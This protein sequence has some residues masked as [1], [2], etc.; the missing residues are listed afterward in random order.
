MTLLD[1]LTVR[2]RIYALA[3]LGVGFALLLVAVFFIG[4][5]RMDQGDVRAAGYEAAGERA[6]ALRIAGLEI[7]RAEKDM[8]LRRDARYVDLNAQARR[9]ATDTVD[10]MLLLTEIQPVRAELETVRD[11]L[12]RYGEAFDAAWGNMVR[13]G[14]DEKSGAQGRLR[15]AVHGVEE[16]VKGVDDAP[17]MVSLLTLRRHEKDFLLRGDP[18]YIERAEKESA[19]FL[20]RLSAVVTDDGARRNLQEKTKFY[21]EKLK[22][23]ALA[24]RESEGAVKRLSDVYAA[25]GPALE[26]VDNFTDAAVVEEKQKME[27]LDSRIRWMIAALSAGGL[28]LSGVLALLISRSIIAPLHQVAGIMSDL[29]AGRRGLP[30]PFTDAGNEIGDMTRALDGFQRGLTEGERLQ[31][32]AK[33]AA[34]RELARADQRDRMVASYDSAVGEM[35]GKVDGAVG[36]VD[37]AAKDM[38]AAAVQVTATSE[39]AACAAE[40]VSANVQTVAA[41]ANELSATTGEISRRVQQ[42]SAISQNAVS[43]IEQTTGEVENLRGM[44]GKIGEVVHLIEAI[45]NQTNLLALNATIEAARAGEAGKGFAVVASEVKNLANQTAKA[46]GDIQEQIAE[47]Q[48]VTRDVVVSI[49]QARTTIR[50]VDEVVTSIASAVEEQNAATQEIARNVQEVAGA[51]ATVA[52]SMN[53]IN[54]Q[55]RVARSLADGLDHAAIDLK[56]GAGDMNRRTEN[57]L[58]EIKAI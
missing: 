27:A 26:K 43:S 53:D 55:A 8:L 22:E 34:Q 11:G 6:M 17:L 9:K 16:A 30:I 58:K 37:Q 41:A 20:S 40:E 57:F 33:A 54:N 25:F 46:T 47:I 32:E 15:E 29:G 28:G 36:Q 44:A 35:L 13:A 38:H 19:V 49:A 23:M 56:K 1:K 4:L 39:S 10:A 5:E 7:R 24:T 51:N 12:K 42:T 21:I 45:A 18:Q 3:G 2:A 52:A 48:S 50:E 31:A 14:L